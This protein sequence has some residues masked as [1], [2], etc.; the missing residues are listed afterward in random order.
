MEYSFSMLPDMSETSLLDK[1]CSD[2]TNSSKD[3]LATSKTEQN[4]SFEFDQQI[5]LGIDSP[6][7]KQNFGKKTESTMVQDNKVLTKQ[8]KLKRKKDNKRKKK[9]E[10]ATLEKQQSSDIDKSKEKLCHHN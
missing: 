3:K 10:L 2:K 6:Q 8:E 4:D 7:K 9:N 5:L 1:I